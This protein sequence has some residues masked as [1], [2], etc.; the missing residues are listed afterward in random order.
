MKKLLIVFIVFPITFA[1]AICAH[2]E[3]G[4]VRNINCG[5]HSFGLDVPPLIRVY[6]NAGTRFESGSCQDVK[7]GDKVE[8]EMRST[9][10]GTAIAS[11]VKVVGHQG[12][13]V[14]QLA[15]NE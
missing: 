6:I 15:S 13:T 1:F 5:S 2:A 10:P 7:E 3:T 8:V 9:G 12:E 14:Q 11:R 4:V